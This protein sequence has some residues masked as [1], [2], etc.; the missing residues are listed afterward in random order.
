M[1][2]QVGAGSDSFPVQI[3][4]SATAAAPLL[5]TDRDFC[6]MPWFLRVGKL[7]QSLDRNPSTVVLFIGSTLTGQ[8]PL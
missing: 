7:P 6:R 1:S 4:A 5:G 2:K 8:L 3:T